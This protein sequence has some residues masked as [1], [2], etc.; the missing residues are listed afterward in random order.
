MGTR[1]CYGFRK[2]GIDKLTYNH[3]DSYPSYLGKIMVTFCKET[4]LDEM[5]AI[6]DRLIMVD[7]GGKPTPEQIE[8]CKKYYDGSVSGGTPEEWYCLLIE[9]QGVPNEYKH[10]LRYMTDAKEFIKDS[11]WCEYAYIIN[12]DT[13]SL[14]FWKGYQKTPDHL[15]RYGTNNN[16]GY[17]PCK[18]VAYYPLEPKYMNQH[19]IDDYVNDM[20]KSCS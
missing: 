1:G 4:S 11:L 10:G 13:N 5:N 19:S 3:Y 12:L 2:N 14:E 8:E 7:E 20:E 6:C 16:R 9:A 15:N 18:M 17:Y